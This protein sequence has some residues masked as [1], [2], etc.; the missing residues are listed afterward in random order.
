MKEGQNVTLPSGVKKTKDEEMMWYFN[1]TRIAMINGDVNTTCYYD[2]NKGIFSGRLYGNV[3]TGSLTIKDIRPEHAGRYE[4]EYSKKS[5]KSETLNRI[6][7]VTCHN[8]AVLNI[9]DRD[10]II[11]IFN[12]VVT[13]SQSKSNK[14]RT[15]E[16]P[17]SDTTSP[18]ETNKPRT[19]EKPVSNISMFS[20]FY[21]KIIF[22]NGLHHV[23][24]YTFD[25]YTKGEIT[26]VFN[27]DENYKCF[28]DHQ[29]II[30]I[31]KEFNFES[32]K[33]I[34]V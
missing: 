14:Q 20:L 19:G 2:V 16:K 18:S 12:V 4:A 33:L 22:T 32:P 29:D 7:E 8:K 27:T 23:S 30:V 6:G 3:S 11:K 9:T 25:L 21:L 1:G 15:G 10:D 34:I 24:K 13:A 26:S 28:F 17:V 5:V 31:S